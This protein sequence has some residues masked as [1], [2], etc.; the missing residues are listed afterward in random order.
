MTEG[1]TKA[2]ALQIHQAG[3]KV[4][5]TPMALQA[6][7]T[8]I[9]ELERDRDGTAR[10]IRES[11]E[12]ESELAENATFQQGSQELD[13]QNRRLERLR[14]LFDAAVE[15]SEPQDGEHVRM[16][17]TFSAD[18]NDGE[19]PELFLLEGDIA[20]EV[21]VKLNPLRLNIRV[22]SI[23]TEAGLRTLIIEPVAGQVISYGE[24]RRNEMRIVKVYSQED[25]VALIKDN[26]IE[27]NREV[28]VA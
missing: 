12:D 10:Y 18:F 21:M 3:E 1:L 2:E 7:E 27:P 11:L 15:Y 26:L 16:G 5:V 28:S 13:L 19:G 17:T 6:L 14:S 8:S 23:N 9:D 4:L 25:D 20:K 24:N 22:L